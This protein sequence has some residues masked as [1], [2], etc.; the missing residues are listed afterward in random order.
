MV[1]LA[2]GTIQIIRSAAERGGY[3]TYAYTNMSYSPNGSLIAVTDTLGNL[4]ILDSQYGRVLHELSGIEGEI[5]DISW[6]PDGSSIAA[7]DYRGKLLIWDVNNGR[8]LLTIIAGENTIRSDWSPS[9][10]FV[11]T[12]D[13]VGKLALWDAKTGETI[14]ILSY[15]DDVGYADLEFSP[16]GR[17]LAGAGGRL[18]LWDVE[19]KKIVGTYS[20]GWE[21]WIEMVRWSP[22]GTRLAILHDLNETCVNFICKYQSRVLSF[23]ILR[24]LNVMSVT[25][26]WSISWSPDGTMISS[27]WGEIWDASNGELLLSSD[28]IGTNIWS[29]DGYYLLANGGVELEFWGID[30]AQSP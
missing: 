5:V 19:K 7:S 16:D 18:L 11:A 25:D 4:R 15:Y 26:G 21:K 29:P 10:D 30:P 28:H 23:P 20:L 9:G 22:D 24:E 3:T 12:I 8:Q 2:K 14:R 27:N 1:D 13:S 17:Y 6:S